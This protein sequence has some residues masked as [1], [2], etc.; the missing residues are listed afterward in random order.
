V[1]WGGSAFLLVWQQQRGG[2]SG[3]DIRGTR[4]DSAGTVLDTGGLAVSDEPGDQREPRVAANG[5]WLVAWLDERTSGGPSP[6]IYGT[7]VA[8]AGTVSDPDGF[9]IADSGEGGPSVAA[10]TGD[11]WAVAYDHFDNTIPG[12]RVFLRTVSP[13]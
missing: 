11:D 6:G 3:F 5:P 7:R 12:T 1:S 2:A 9:R 8:T 10:A 13:K 4:I